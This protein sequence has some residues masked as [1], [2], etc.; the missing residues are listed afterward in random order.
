MFA[1]GVA[2]PA[3]TASAAPPT[4]QRAA[5]APDG[6][7]E[8]GTPALR[9]QLEAASKGYLDAKRALDTSVQ[10]QQQLATQ[11]K[12]T[13]AELN[14]RSGKVGEIAGVAYRTGRL[15]AMSA[16]LNSN[17]PEGFMDRAAAL[18]AVAANEDRVLRDLLA[19]K[20]EA[21]RT[22]VALDG[23]IREQ[24]KQVAVMAKRKEQAERALTVATTPKPQ[25]TADTG[26]NRGASTANAKAA[27]R[28]SDGSWPSESCS[29]NDPTP[30][31]GCITPRTL[32]ALNQAKA[33]GFTRYVSCHRSGGSGEHPKGRACDFAAQK[34]GFG[35][36]ATGGDKTYGNN[37]A[38]YF[39]R[40]A[41]RL[42]VL[43]VIWYRQIWLPSSGW[44]SYSGAGG[45]PSSDHTNH[46]HLSV[47]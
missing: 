4:A 25:T 26:S 45:D 46:V 3:G 20:D 14:A 40:N 44:K 38:A 17:T 18:D 47:Y 2:L 21:T 36:D 1:L 23:E 31:S 39:I 19:A 6:D 27:P 43:Y 34:N 28:N 15:G 41:D 32:H 35:G 10:R 9:A 42:A 29:V 5:A 7:E 24:R 8:G 16:L 37:L 12:T 30:A 11:L 13:E 33:A 22:R